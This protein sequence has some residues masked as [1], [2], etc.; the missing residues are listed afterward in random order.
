LRLG[1]MAAF[2]WV[3]HSVTSAGCCWLRDKTMKR[4]ASSSAP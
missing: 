2:N 3:K 4:E 1:K